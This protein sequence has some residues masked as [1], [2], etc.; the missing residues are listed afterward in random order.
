MTGTYD[1]TTFRA[2]SFHDVTEQFRRGSDTPRDYL[3]RCL[4]TIG[5]REPTVQAYVSLNEDGAR[6]AADASSDRWRAGQPLSAID[7]MPVSIKDLLETRDMPTQMGCE[8]YAGNFPKRDNAAVWA[9]REAGAVVLGKT[10]TA[11]LGGAHPGPTTNPFDV[12]RTPGGSSSGSAAAV[13]A[14]MVP[15]A[16]GTQV[17]GSIIRPSGYCGNLAL[18]PTQGGVNRGERQATSMS[19][20]G[21]HA[22][23][24]E[25]MWRVAAEI[26]AR[27]GGDRGCAGLQGPLAAPPAQRPQRLLVLETEGWSRLDEASRITFEQLLE[28]LRGLGIE[29]LRRSDHRLLEALEQ[30]VADATKTASAITAWENQWAT[31]NLVALHPD[32]VS[33]RAKRALTLA[34]S[35]TFA[36]YRELLLRREHAQSTHQALAGT[37]DATIAL[38][39][40]GPA[41]LWSG[42]VAGEPLAP[43]PT[44]DAV[45]NYA[46]SLLF[47]PC[48][49][50]PLLAV[51]G[52]PVGVQLIGQ[53]QDDARMAAHARWLMEHVQPLSANSD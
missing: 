32:S 30:S 51:D 20:H 18:K 44:G 26:V 14:Q 2:L 38:S 12:T 46:T 29:I 39:C 15:A 45:F 25:D 53:Q 21:V 47:A 35:M 33:E 28:A 22:G 36:D 10:V 7:G 31:R 49:S 16:I 23:N 1:P 42:D 5:T 34:D 6:A 52:M 3:E 41:P 48:V 24:I 17:G 4:D 13:A 37:A 27:I 43:R 11:E 19:T 9:L 40:P 50:M 8:A